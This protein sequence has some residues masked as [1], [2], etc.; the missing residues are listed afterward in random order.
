MIRRNYFPA[1][2]QRFIQTD[3]IGSDGGLALDQLILQGQQR[4]LGIQHRLKVNQPGGILVA[5]KPG[6][7]LRRPGGSQ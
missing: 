3:Q 5:G 7:A 2:T 4:T 1:A 6:G